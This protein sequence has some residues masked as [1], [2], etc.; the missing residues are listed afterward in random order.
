[1]QLSDDQLAALK[2]NLLSRFS[3]CADNSTL[4]SSSPL[5]TSILLQFYSGVSVPRPGE[6]KTEVLKGR[7]HL[8]HRICGLSF[9]V[10]HGSFFQTNTKVIV[11]HPL[12]NY[13]KPNCT[14]KPRTELTLRY[15]FLM[16]RLRK[17]S[18]T[19]LLHLPSGYLLTIM[20]YTARLPRP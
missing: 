14:N 12:S 6:A 11:I 9:Q 15:T 5:P 7:E 2:V 18:I 13:Y 16:F 20:H 19:A 3:A 17:S 8:V 1:M 4:T 10:S